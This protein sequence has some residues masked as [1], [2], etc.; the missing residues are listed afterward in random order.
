MSMLSAFQAKGRFFRGNLHGHS[1]RSDGTI[2]P[3]EVCRRYKAAGYDFVAVTDHFLECFDFPMTDT[4][5][6][7]DGAFTTILGAEM[8]APKTRKGE[9]WHILAVNLPVDFA[10]TGANETGPEL[11]RRCAE[12]G[13]F[14]AVAH[15]AW[16]QLELADAES[17]DVAH[18]IEVYNHSS[19]MTADRGDGTALL[20]EIL[21]TGR[22]L[23]CIA[24]DDSHWHVDDAFGGWVMVKSEANE[25]E[26]L[27]AALKTGQYYA[28]QGPEIHDI[29][30]EGSSLRISCTAARAVMLLG[31]GSRIAQVLG[32]AL[33][34]TVLPLDKFE[35]GWC[36]AVVV[37]AAGRRA[38]SNPLWP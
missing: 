7:R 20:E 12:A 25:P 23:G 19:Q 8:H 11:A 17:I 37:D 24:T 4:T 3:D 2:D 5:R 14:V 30:R 9:V 36:R 16:Y 21:C 33:T 34:E 18:A 1:T 13:A 35:A 10:A 29:R 22:G 31:K 32:N 38:W 28:S 26:A 15:P 6:F 27:T